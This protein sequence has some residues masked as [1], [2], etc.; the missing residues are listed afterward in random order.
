[1]ESA[2]QLLH[3]RHVDRLDGVVGQQTLVFPNSVTN[4]R[5]RVTVVDRH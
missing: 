4:H 5:A 1:M 2:L 3:G